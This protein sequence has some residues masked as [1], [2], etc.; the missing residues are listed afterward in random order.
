[1]SNNTMVRGTVT[2]SLTSLQTSNRAEQNMAESIISI[3]ILCS[4][5]PK[6]AYGRQGLDWDRWA[7]IQFSQVHFGAFCHSRGG[8]TDLLWSKKRHV[9]NGG[10]Q[11]TSFGPKNVTSLTGGPTDLLWSKKRHVTERGDQ[12]TSFGPKNFTSLTGG[13]N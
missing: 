13:T 7:R 1:M 3:V 12:L 2:R 8:P 9:T 6:P 4:T 5:R 10:V 11:L